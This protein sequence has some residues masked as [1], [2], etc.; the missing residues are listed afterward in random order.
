MARR[1]QYH[2]QHAPIHSLPHIL[3][4][5]ISHPDCT[6][7]YGNSAI[8]LSAPVRVE[9]RKER[10]ARERAEDKVRDD[11]QDAQAR[12]AAANAHAQAMA[13]GVPNHAHNDVGHAEWFLSIYGDNLRYVPEWGI[14]LIWGGYR[15]IKDTHGQA[16]RQLGV[17]FSKTVGKAAKAGSKEAKKDAT[18]MGQKKAINNM[19]AIAS[20]YPAVSVSASALDSNTMLL[21]V[22]NGVCDLKTATFREGRREDLITQ[23]AAVQYDAGS[24]APQWE[25]F[26]LEAMRGDEDMVQYLQMWV[27]YILTGEVSEQAFIFLFGYGEN[28]KSVFTD[29]LIKLMGTYAQKA[30]NALIT[31]DK[32]GR[33]PL[34]DIARL[35]GKRLVICSEIGDGDKL[36]ESRVKDL[37]GG[38]TA[39]GRL[40]YQQTFEFK[41]QAKL[42]LFGNHLVTI[43]S[44][45]K[46]IW[47]RI[48]LI[49]F[50]VQ[51]APDKIDRNLAAKLYTEF[52]GILNWALMGCRQWQAKGLISPAGVSKATDE[53][54]EQEDILGDW[55]LEG[56]P[57]PDLNGLTTR[58]AMYSSYA[59][60]CA[61]NG[62]A[63]ASQKTFGKRLR[64]RGY[65]DYRKANCRYWGKMPP[66]GN[67]PEDPESSPD[68][69]GD[70]TP[71]EPAASLPTVQAKLPL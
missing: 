17:Q 10:R 29:V 26:V 34:N 32:H 53:F 42:L 35:A 63:C 11:Q 61:D 25:K 20:T 64:E 38:E 71:A 47:R 19:L 23:C 16:V 15:W 14:W 33:E 7:T 56:M 45:D 12:A 48:R 24:T 36:A 70:T 3:P 57:S 28:G 30:S 55:M 9:T 40:L 67:I 68:P 13:G 37:T 69:L 60:Y 46:G 44:G 21:G 6:E 43:P 62:H 52:S 51:I 31:V 8:P 49:Q 54:R 2:S 4:D 27:G 41:P 65:Y 22:E 39:A 5:M 1:H 59:Q 66:D 50:L 58:R 18:E